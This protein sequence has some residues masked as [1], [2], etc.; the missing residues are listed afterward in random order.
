MIS[1]TFASFSRTLKF[2]IP[3]KYKGFSGTYQNV[4]AFAKS[5]LEP[6]MF[7]FIQCN[8]LL[9]VRFYVV[10]VNIQKIPVTFLFVTDF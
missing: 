7:I 2:S 1:S 6:E 8:L 9:N 4:L 5:S 3:T 10:L